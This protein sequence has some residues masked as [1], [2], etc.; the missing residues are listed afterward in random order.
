ML[1]IRYRN[2]RLLRA[3]NKPTIQVGG[4]D[5][6]VPTPE[7]VREA[8]AAEELDKASAASSLRRKR[9]SA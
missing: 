1:D 9:G 7:Q 2:R 3:P 4:M 6:L 8:V 5:Q